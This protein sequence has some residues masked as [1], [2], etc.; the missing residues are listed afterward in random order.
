MVN[1]AD[2][3]GK[4]VGK[5]KGCKDISYGLIFLAIILF[6]I[7]SVA[8]Y[9]VYKFIISAPSNPPN[10]PNSDLVSTVV[11]I[12]GVIVLIV[13]L[14]AAAIIFKGLNLTDKTQSLGLPE[15]SVRAVIALSLILIFMISSIL[16]YDR[17]NTNGRVQIINSKGITQEQLN[18]IPTAEI[19]YIQR[20]GTAGN[21][22]LFDVGLI[23]QTSKTSEDIAKQIITTV[24]TL[25]VAVA[26]FY[27]GSKAAAAAEAEGA[28]ATSVPVIRSIDPKDNQGKR[29]EDMVFTINGKNLELAKEVK[30]VQGSIEIQCTDITTSSTVVRCK[31]KIP[32]DTQKYPT[33]NWTVVVTNSDKGEDKYDGFNVSK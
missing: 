11:L 32:I 13:A 24:S 1:E 16:L 30:L 8:T 17:V 29:D 2:Q 28:P 31:L 19:A 14:S 7:L 9:Y 25:V 15:G 18:A 27:F 12:F 22:T 23:L 4:A 20:N 21:E 3:I 10:A 6:F 33:G 26:G 5:M